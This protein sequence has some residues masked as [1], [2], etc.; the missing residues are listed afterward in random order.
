LIRQTAIFDPI[1]IA[2]LMYWYVLY[3]VHKLMFGK[4]LAAIA[5]ACHD[6]KTKAE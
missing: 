4:M 3:P 2:G 1:G 6:E 5:A